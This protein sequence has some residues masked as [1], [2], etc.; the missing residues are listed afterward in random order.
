MGVTAT[1]VT[2]AV[3]IAGVEGL[4]MNAVTASVAGYALGIVVNYILNYQYTFNSERHHKVVF[5]RFLVV[6]VLGML[7]NAFLMYT[8]INWLGFH[9]I[10]AQLFAVAIIFMLSFTANRLWTFAD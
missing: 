10:L 4:H 6:A 1:I 5:P 2:Y 7:M 9:Y 3:L 8:G